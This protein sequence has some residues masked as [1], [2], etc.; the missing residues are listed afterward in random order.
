MSGYLEAT[1]II[2]GVL[3]CEKQFNTL[4]S[5]EEWATRE[6]HKVEKES[7]EM[8]AEIYV[9]GHHN[10]CRYSECSCVQYLTDH[11]PDFFSTNHP[12]YAEL[13]GEK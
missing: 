11:H 9:M 1:L 7:P 3:D 6:I 10:E 12:R 2:D 8:V 13:R 4:S 5:L